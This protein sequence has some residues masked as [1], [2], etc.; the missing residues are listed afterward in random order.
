MSDAAL[1][2]A[3]VS[4]AV[5]TYIDAPWSLGGTL[6]PTLPTRSERSVGNFAVSLG[7]L[8]LAIGLFLRGY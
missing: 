6:R 5:A 4:F 1:L 2:L 3:A 7:F 8:W